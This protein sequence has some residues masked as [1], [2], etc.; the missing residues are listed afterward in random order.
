MSYSISL[1]RGVNFQS[2]LFP[3]LYKG[4]DKIPENRILYK[5]GQ[6]RVPAMEGSMNL[7]GFVF[8]PVFFFRG[9]TK[10]PKGDLTKYQKTEY[11]TNVG[12]ERGLLELV[13]EPVVPQ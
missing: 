4:L 10:N 5:Y 13:N 9:L 3:S 8:S 1:M 6:G 7:M 11:P 2:F 12:S